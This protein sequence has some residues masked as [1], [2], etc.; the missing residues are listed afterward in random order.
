MT[1]RSTADRASKARMSEHKDVRVR[2]GAR[3]AS[4]AGKLSRHDVGETGMPGAMVFGYFLPK[5]KVARSPPR[6]A[7][8][9]RKRCVLGTQAKAL[10]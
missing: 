1:P 9:K 8:P 3:S 6:R 7:K 4:I 2:A 5:Q 10:G